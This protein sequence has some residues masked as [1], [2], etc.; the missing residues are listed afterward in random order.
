[1]ESDGKLFKKKNKKLKNSIK[2]QK[3]I[4][5]RKN[6]AFSRFPNY[7]FHSLFSNNCKIPHIPLLS[8]TLQ[9]VQPIQNYAKESHSAGG[10]RVR[11][12]HENPKNEFQLRRRR[13]EFTQKRPLPSPDE[14]IARAL[15][16]EF[17]FGRGIV[18][19]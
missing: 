4:L 1:M 16:L 7:S 9:T 6:N 11:K 10:Y 3:T 5:F 15:Q 8:R 18:P 19:E 14:P 12:T 17:G 2:N 13:I